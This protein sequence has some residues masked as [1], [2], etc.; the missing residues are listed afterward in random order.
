MITP[1]A[2]QLMEEKQEE[3]DSIEPTRIEQ[4]KLIQARIQRRIEEF[5]QVQE[6]RMDNKQV[7]NAQNELKRPLTPFEREQLDIQFLWD[8]YSKLP[9]KFVLALKKVNKSLVLNLWTTQFKVPAEHP[10]GSLDSLIT[11]KETLSAFTEVLGTRLTVFCND[12]GLRIYKHEGKWLYETLPTE[13][14]DKDRVRVRRE[15]AARLYANKEIRTLLQSKMIALK[16]LLPTAND[17]KI[18]GWMIALSAPPPNAVAS[19]DP[20][21]K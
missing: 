18:Q 13:E 20:E 5:V 9:L 12:G 14:H 17:L 4:V 7:K 6:E 2:N 16:E 8:L 3:L 15:N 10:K 11:D 21:E 19:D 1:K